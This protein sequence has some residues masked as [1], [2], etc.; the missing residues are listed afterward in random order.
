MRAAR[1]RPNGL[2]IYLIWL[3]LCLVWVGA[4]P[5]VEGGRFQGGFRVVGRGSLP[6]CFGLVVLLWSVVGVIISEYVSFLY[7]W[8]SL[9][10]RVIC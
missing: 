3:D 1:C 6:S 4:S 9:K 7:G 8:V 2:S 5:W 10:F